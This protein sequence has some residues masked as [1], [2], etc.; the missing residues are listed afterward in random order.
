[1]ASAAGGFDGVVGVAGSLGFGGVVAVREHAV[2]NIV[3]SKI[4][5]VTCTV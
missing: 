3:E 2:S 5:N 1:M 4:R